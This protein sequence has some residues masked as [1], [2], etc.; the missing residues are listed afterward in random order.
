MEP[1]SHAQSRAVVTMWDVRCASAYLPRGAPAHA[2]LA[3]A[4]LG[5]RAIYA[6]IATGYSFRQ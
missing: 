6:R 4:W 3:A 1:D 5:R 2:A